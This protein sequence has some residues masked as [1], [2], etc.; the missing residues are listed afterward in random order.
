MANGFPASFHA[1]CAACW[2]K[3]ALGQLVFMDDNAPRY[4][5]APIPH[6]RLA[7]AGS[8]RAPAAPI[9]L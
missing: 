9:G 3:I 7:W 8:G 2:K 6:N 4:P 1:T 5:D